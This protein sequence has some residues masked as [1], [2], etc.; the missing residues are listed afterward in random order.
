MAYYNGQVKRMLFLA[1]P[2][3]TICTPPDFI[4]HSRR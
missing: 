2:S 4:I 3:R 1:R